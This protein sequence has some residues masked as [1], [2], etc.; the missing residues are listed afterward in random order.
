MEE[1]PSTPGEQP[2]AGRSLRRNRRLRLACAR[3]QKRKI[4]C[5]G[6]YP[7]CNNCKKASATCTD[8]DSLRLR[9]VP[10]E[11]DETAADLRKRISFLE[12]VLREQL[13]S[14][15]IS[16]DN[17]R[18]QATE[19]PLAGSGGP[20]PWIQTG[21][22]ALS[23]EI[24]L[25]SVGNSSAPRYLGPSSGYFLSRMLIRSSSSAPDR[26]PSRAAD[27]HATQGR[28]PLPDQRR[29]H[30]LCNA[31][32][33]TIAPQYPIL[34]RPSFMQ[35]LD[36]L[37]RDNRPSDGPDD[38]AVFQVNMVLA[39]G[40]TILS[41]R[42][43]LSLPAESYC[44]SAMD[45]FNNINFENSLPGLQCLL[46]LLIFTMYNPH[47]RLNAWYLN[48]Q[49]IAV[50]LDLGLQRNITTSSGI[51]LLEQEMRTRLFWVV[52][53]MDRTIATIMGRPIGLRDE[54]C[55]LR[56]PQLIDDQDLSD[57]FP[58]ATVEAEP[59]AASYMSFALHFFKLA[60]LNSEIKYVANSI[61]RDTPLYA[62][63]VVADIQQWQGTVAQQLDEWAGEIPES[64]KENAY[65]VAICRLQYYS[66]L[67]LLTRPSPAI[68]N[69]SIE[70]LKRC[71][72]S[73]RSC[74]HLFNRMYRDDMLIYSWTTF[75]SLLLSTVTMLY[76]IR[77]VP[78][79][80]CQIEPDA[81]VAD[82]GIS[83]SV[84]SAAGEHWPGAKRSRDMLEDLVRDIVRW[85]KEAA[86]RWQGDA[87]GQPSESVSIMG[88]TM[89]TAGVGGPLGEFTPPDSTFSYI[90]P[91]ADTTAGFSFEDWWA[92][93]LPGQ[94]AMVD[95]ANIDA[96][97]HSLFADMTP[98]GEIL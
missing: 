41:H 26:N 65:M 32:F 89:A 37:Y 23:H 8:G 2:F 72:D 3:C 53:S 94:S 93:S 90:Q 96:L 62:Y 22:N 27:P 10:R 51:S 98:T 68:P 80:A 71:Y 76:C 43:K 20:R 95:P 46:L 83:L 47:V 36:S 7:T 28:L 45:H 49:C 59:G 21:S 92:S 87:Q 11:D 48:Y 5:D 4:R 35:I 44:L 33:D 14:Y 56:L 61:V 42:L 86:K 77:T 54:A 30:Q 17:T 73:C 81:L 12:S 84:L 50:L 69:P 52:F 91:Q 6:Q 31:F 24:G 63:P 66:L 70:S 82:V 13:P 85:V 79:I 34:H 60:R 64:T 58:S 78:T 9:D 74:V 29:A 15:D 88:M 40:A 55:E 19:T 67:I 16:R 18:A 57:T 97:M 39:I 38:A 1:Q 75:H 25:V